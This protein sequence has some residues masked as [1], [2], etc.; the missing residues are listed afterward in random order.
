MIGFTPP[1]IPNMAY[2]LD[3]AKGQKAMGPTD[4]GLKFPKIG[5]KIGLFSQ[6]DYYLQ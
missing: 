4:Y 3:K 6:Q 2:F 1:L 5:A